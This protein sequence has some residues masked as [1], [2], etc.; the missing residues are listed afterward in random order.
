MDHRAKLSSVL[1]KRS[2][3]AIPTSPI[4]WRDRGFE[5]LL[6]HGRMLEACLSQRNSIS[7]F[8]D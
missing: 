6:L 8:S 1:P 4:S 5:S 2:N 3:G 7:A